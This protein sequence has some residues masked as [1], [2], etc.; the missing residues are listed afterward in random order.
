MYM[1][2]KN[3]FVFAGLS[4]LTVSVAVI[5][6]SFPIHPP[7][8][9]DAGE[10]VAYSEMNFPIHPPILTQ[11]EEQVAYSGMNFPIHPPIL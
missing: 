5:I 7:I 1:N 4:I 9:T 6:M 2:M 3:N 10:Q 11:T 8:L